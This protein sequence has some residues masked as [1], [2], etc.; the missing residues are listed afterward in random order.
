MATEETIQRVPRGLLNVIGNFGGKTPPVL[1]AEVHGQLELLQMFGLHQLQSLAASNAAAAEGVGVVVTPSARDWTILFA[2]S[3]TVVKTAT[4]TALR[5]LCSVNRTGGAAVVIREEEGGPF[6]ATETGN[7]TVGGL[8]P[9]PLLLPPGST[10]QAS[11]PI[12]G[13]DATAFVIVTA[14]FGLLG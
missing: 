10:V 13:T 4:M 6:G 2:A 8:L 12:I 1:A 5:V 11:A 14:E 7:V 3:G 9:Y